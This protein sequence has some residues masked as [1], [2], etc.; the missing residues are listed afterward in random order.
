MAAPVVESKG[1]AA[2]VASGTTVAPTL[3]GSVAANDVLFLLAN[4]YTGA[5]ANNTTFTDPGG[6]TR[7]TAT[8]YT[9]QFFAN[10]GMVGL[11]WLRATGGESGTVT[12]VR[13]GT[14]TEV[15]QAQV[16]RV[17]GAETTGNPWDQVVVNAASGG[18]ANL[19]WPAVTVLGAQRTLL[20]VY[21]NGANANIGTVTAS[22]LSLYTSLGRDGT[23]LGSTSSVEA[24]YD[25]G[26]A[27]A[28]QA[29]S[30]GGGSVNGWATVH[31]SLTPV[32]VPWPDP[33][34]HDPATLRVV[35]SGYRNR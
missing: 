15:F 26:V 6:W 21:V 16:Y 4:S 18:G 17:S 28:Q 31:I 24:W 30:T 5:G 13:G 11:W 19:S 33:A 14:T 22:D 12:L 35:Q 7:V 3:P 8:A 1:T 20:A 27:S 25:S 9:N 2:A 34:Y 23:A 32:S 29:D 10:N